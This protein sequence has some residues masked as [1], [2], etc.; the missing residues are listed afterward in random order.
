MNILLLNRVVTLLIRKL[1]LKFPDVETLENTLDSLDSLI[2]DS[3]LEHH[4]TENLK[5]EVKKE[6]ASY[7]TK[8]DAEVY[9]RTFDLMLLKRLRE[10][11]DIPR[12]S[13][14]YL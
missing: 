10:Q 13:L 8:M 11:A 2:D 4:S 1:K 5:S 7:R 14:F 3:L 12:L 9:R 6:L